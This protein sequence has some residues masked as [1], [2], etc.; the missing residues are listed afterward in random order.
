M[1]VTYLYNSICLSPGHAAILVTSV[2]SWP[3]LTRNVRSINEFYLL[4]CSI[5]AQS[6]SNLQIASANLFSQQ[7]WHATKVTFV[8]LWKWAKMFNITTGGILFR[9]AETL[10]STGALFPL[11]WFWLACF[12]Q[13]LWHQPPLPNLEHAC[14]NSLIKV[15]ATVLT[16]S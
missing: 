14:K 3:F 15:L 10:G 11:D 2:H 1:S 4:L 9:A 12:W 5:T 6:T 16:F 7:I 13:P 8:L